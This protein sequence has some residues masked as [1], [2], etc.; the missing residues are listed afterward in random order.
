[1]SSFNREEETKDLLNGVPAAYY[2]EREITKIGNELSKITRDSTKKQMISTLS[3]IRELAEY[4]LSAIQ[5]D[6]H[7]AVRE[8]VE[9]KRYFSESGYNDGSYLNSYVLKFFSN[10]KRKRAVVDIGLNYTDDSI[11]IYLKERPKYILS[12]SYRR[13]FRLFG[14]QL[15]GKTSFS[16]NLPAPNMF[17]LTSRGNLPTVGFDIDGVIVSHKPTYS[18]MTMNWLETVVALTI[19][20]VN[21][22][23]VVMNIPER[24]F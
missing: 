23:Q 9:S 21:N 5:L 11:V 8:F 1:M 20:D 14:M 18:G 12:M 17:V 3:D 15:R 6:D 10:E 4:A 13:F 7:S 2:P 19:Q 22:E 24:E 16:G